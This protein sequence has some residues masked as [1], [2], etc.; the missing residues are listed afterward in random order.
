MA[1]PAAAASTNTSQTNLSR[2]PQSKQPQQQPSAPQ[3]HKRQHPSQPQIQ[4]ASLSAPSSHPSL[5]TPSSSTSPQ[6]TGLTN[7]WKGIKS[8]APFRKEEPEVAPKGNL[9][10]PLLLRGL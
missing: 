10:F 8:K 6:R 7:W 2:P 1:A 9:T 3:Q 4:T 5:T